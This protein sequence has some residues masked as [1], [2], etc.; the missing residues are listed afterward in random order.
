MSADQAASMIASQLAALGVRAGGL[1][2]VHS[3]LRSL[4]TVPGGAETVICGLLACLAERGTLLLPALSYMAVGRQQ[5]RFDLLRTPSCVGLIPET[6]RTMPGVRRSLHPTHSVCALGPA[7]AALLDGHHLDRTPVGEHSPFR[8]LAQAGGQ[9]LMLGCG[10]RPNTSM[11]GVEE[12]TSPP[13]L[14]HPDRIEYE[15]A[16]ETGRAH[17]DLHSVH[18]FR[19]RSQR[20][21][22]IEPLMPPCT[23]RTGRVLEAT[24]HLLEASVMW[25][26]ARAALERDALFFV[27]PAGAQPEP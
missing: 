19:G 3:S 8:L 12:L 13:Y 2:L 23:L 24:C 22:R 21:D 17:R 7:A 26:A 5:P 10:L 18:D 9:L 25:D 6:F 14:M 16:D 1:L 27:D 15:L 4:G 20:Y 11:H